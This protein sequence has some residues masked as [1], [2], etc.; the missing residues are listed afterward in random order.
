MAIQWNLPAS[1]S[2]GAYIDSVRLTI[3]YHNYQS[4]TLAVRF[5]N[6]DY[7]IL[8]RNRNDLFLDIALT[9][10][11]EIL[12]GSGTYKQRIHNDLNGSEGTFFWA[13]QDETYVIAPL[14]DAVQDAIDNGQDYFSLL[15]GGMSYYL[16]KVWSIKPIDVLLEVYY[17]PPD[18]EYVDGVTI[19]N[20]VDG[21]RDWDVLQ[22]SL[23]RGDENIFDGPDADYTELPQ[24]ETPPATR[25]WLT[26]YNHL[27]ETF[28]AK[29]EDQSLTGRHKFKHWNE[30]DA[31]Y[32]VRQP[33][34]TWD[35][36]TDD[37]RAAA[38]TATKT[39]NLVQREITHGYTGLSFDFKDPWRVEQDLNETDPPI[40]QYI[41]DGFIEQTTP[42]EPWTD[43]Q[44]WGVFKDMDRDLD[45]HYATRFW[46]YYDYDA[47]ADTYSRKD[48][49]PLDEGDLIHMDQISYG[50]GMLVSPAGSIEY[51]DVTSSGASSRDYN[52]EYKGG[53][54]QADLTAVYKAHRLSDHEAQPTRSA[55]Q[56]KLDIDPDSVYHLVYGSAG[57]VWYTQS[58]DGQIWSPEEL[59]SDYT[60]TATNPSLAVLDSSVYVTYYEDG[61]IYLR[62]RYSGQWYDYFVDNGNNHNGAS[63]TPVVEAAHFQD[64]GDVV[65]VL[66]DD[67]EEIKYYCTH[68]WYTGK[69]QDP[70]SHD[71]ADGA[72]H[73][74]PGTPPVF[75]AITYLNSMYEFMAAW[76]EGT[77]IKTAYMRAGGGSWS[78]SDLYRFFEVREL[79]DASLLSDSV[80]FAPSITTDHLD[81]SVV[82]YE[83][84][85]PSGGYSNRWVNVRTYDWTSGTWNTTIYQLPYYSATGYGEPISASIGAHSTSVT[86][87]G[88]D[89]GRG[90]RVAFNKN[91]GGGI[92]VGK[93]DCS[94]SAC[95]QLTDGEAFPS[96]VPFAPNGLLREV[97]SFPFQ[98]GPFMHAV[99]TTNNALTKACVPDMRMV[100]DLRV[101]IG[102]DIAIL[103]ITSLSVLHGNDVRDE[104]EWY[105][106]PDTLVIGDDAPVQEVLRSETFTI[107][108]GDR[109][110]YRT[111]LYCSDPNAMPSGVSIAVQLRRAGNDAILQQFA[112]PLRNFPTDTAMWNDW[113]RNLSALANE[114]VYISLGI[115]GTLPGSATAST[116]KVWLEGQYI[117]KASAGMDRGY[118]RP[119]TIQLG[120]NHPNPFSG[121]TIIPFFLPEAQHLRL[122]IHDLLGRE[123]AVIVDDILPAGSHERRFDGG[124]FVPGTYLIRLST[125]H[126]I[127]SR[128]MILT[129]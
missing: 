29:F 32:K 81:K 67:H 101:G 38:D 74:N 85:V 28:F 64:G 34:G 24:F 109:F 13:S 96:V 14:R 30:T 75:P 91:W 72:V 80:V 100:R 117:P 56:R 6:A 53:V 119:S 18:P 33:T 50:K 9:R 125:E 59:V 39:A 90:L 87:G 11:P 93:F 98:I 26:W 104:V 83:V 99:R 66:W 4:L 40:A 35:G 114:T 47:G 63:T 51:S 19:T 77:Q 25:S 15:I 58:Q 7:E 76:R 95:D 118:P 106:L 8:S 102:N 111:M 5:Y 92:R 88:G 107:N 86:C 68:L 12:Q 121:E 129:H 82:A 23:V 60:H 3:Q 27:T 128:T 55:N 36:T 113:T 16:N 69:Y 2:E 45:P 103:G 21:I 78:R 41:R 17:T 71:Y 42:Y 65:L 57:E 127:V 108:N 1:L 20:V 94:Y 49:L 97:Y 46:K 62:R 122:T 52:L 61:Y 10:E 48:G 105:E 120:Q 124:P 54:P 89:L 73:Q 44:S 112:L 116:A 43:S 70:Y 79:A 22:E 115:D 126:E 31:L 37:Y 123:I 84:K 110:E